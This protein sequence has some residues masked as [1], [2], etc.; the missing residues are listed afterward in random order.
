M[1][2]PGIS[3]T[4][5]SEPFLIT[6]NTP[7]STGTCSVFICHILVISISS[8]LY[9]LDSLSETS[10]EV[11]Y[12]YYYHYHYHYYYHYQL[13]L[14]SVYFQ[15]IPVETGSINME[16]PPYRYRY[17]NAFTETGSLHME[18]SPSPAYYQVV[19]YV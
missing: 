12:Y 7:T 1:M 8:S 10:M 19:S 16:P 4:S 14:L 9:L 15:D 3:L 11:I 5:F 6:P 13:H 2:F 18:T 17:Q